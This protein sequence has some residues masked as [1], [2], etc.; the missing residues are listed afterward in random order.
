MVYYVTYNITDVLV[1]LP[2]RFLFSSQILHLGVWYYAYMMAL[3][4]FSTNA[5]NIIAGA[6]GV[7]GVQSAIIATSLIVI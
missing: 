3:A 5:I 7:E 4:V 1:P 2:L 6:N